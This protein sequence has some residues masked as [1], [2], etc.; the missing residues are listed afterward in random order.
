MSVPSVLAI[1]YLSRDITVSSNLVQLQISNHTPIPNRFFP[2]LRLRV[3][4]HSFPRT[5]HS[6]PSL[7]IRCVCE[8]LTPN[9]PL[10][11]FRTGY[12]PRTRRTDL[13]SLSTWAALPLLPSAPCLLPLH[14][15]FFPKSALIP[16]SPRSKFVMPRGTR[17]IPATGCVSV[18][19]DSYRGCEPEQVD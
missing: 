10:L 13:N 2:M 18:D 9:V 17:S 1:S 11:T 12:S 16:P 4:H 5:F 6:S 3:R 7:A 14:W 15:I 8:H 19:M